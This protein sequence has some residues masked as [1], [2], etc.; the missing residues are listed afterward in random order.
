MAITFPTLLPCLHLEHAL[1]RSSLRPVVILHSNHQFDNLCSIS[2][3]TGDAMAVQEAMS[4][5][6]FTQLAS[7]LDTEEAQVK[8]VICMNV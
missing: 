2:V 3:G 5:G 6:E 1:P 4:R 8:L 7:I